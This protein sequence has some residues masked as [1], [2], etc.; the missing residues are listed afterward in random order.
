MKGDPWE[1][2]KKFRKNFEKE[3]FEQCHSA[4]K[5]KWEDPLGFFD[6][7]CVAK[8]RNK[9]RGDPLVQSKK[10]Q[11]KSHSA[12]KN[13]SEKHQRGIL[14]M[15]SVFEVRDVDVFV[16]DEVLAFR[17]CFGRP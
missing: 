11:K 12:E 16:L 10:F 17:V 3:I 4:E 15:F 7:P 14:S 2:F 1:V 13:R 5:C 9:R 6:I 8:Y